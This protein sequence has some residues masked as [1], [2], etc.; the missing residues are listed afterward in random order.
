[1]KKV[2]LLGRKRIAELAGHQDDVTEVKK[3]ELLALK[4]QA[5]NNEAKAA[6]TLL[7]LPVSSLQ[8]D[9]NQPRKVFRNLDPLAASIKE[10]GIIQPIIVTPKNAQG[11]YT[12]IAGE[13]RFRAAQKAQLATV[14]CI[15]RQENDANILILQLLENSQREDV[16]PLE[17]ASALM[18]LIHGMRLSKL[19]VAKELG[20]EPAWI[21]IRLGLLQASDSIKKLVTEGVVEDIRT[22]HELRM[23]EA[24]SPGVAEELIG[25]I[26]R[27]QVSGSYR[28]AIAQAREKRLDKAEVPKTIQSIERVGNQL[29]LHVGGKRP[30]TFQ[31]SQ[32]V[33]ANFVSELLR[34]KH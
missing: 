28:Q 2:S 31:V 24:E 34:T 16:S 12:I 10:K 1:M 21:S 8:A 22:L 3:E 19:Q 6:G 25:R 11:I 13:R 23:L 33:L 32:E 29:V 27:N 30:L 4:L 7:S 15:V 14:P 20:R 17:E 9:P 26:R 5:L 18:Q